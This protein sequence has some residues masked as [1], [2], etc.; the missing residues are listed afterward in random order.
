[1]ERI[2]KEKKNQLKNL[3]LKNLEKKKSKALID[4]HSVNKLLI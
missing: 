4:L 1:M 3:Y 2:L